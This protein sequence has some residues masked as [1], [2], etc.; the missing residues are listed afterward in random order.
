MAVLVERNDNQDDD[1]QRH[2]MFQTTWIPGKMARSST[3]ATPL[4]EDIAA[5]EGGGAR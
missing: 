4:D 1:C 5:S 3:E 2:H